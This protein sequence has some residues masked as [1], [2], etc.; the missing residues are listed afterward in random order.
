MIVETFPTENICDTDGHN[1]YTQVLLHIRIR[2]F[3][4]FNLTMC[5]KTY[6]KEASNRM[7]DVALL[8]TQFI[9]R[10]TSTHEPTRWIL[11]SG[12]LRKCV[13]LSDMLQILSSIPGF[14]ETCPS[15]LI[16]PC[17]HTAVDDICDLVTELQGFDNLSTGTSPRIPYIRD[18]RMID[19]FLLRHIFTKTIRIAQRLIAA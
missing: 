18:D 6:N 10:C 5:K 13:I 12:E 16:W 2:T 17:L 19:Q 8:R 9:I 14:F 4:I 15:E 7:I 11:P 1:S 3:I